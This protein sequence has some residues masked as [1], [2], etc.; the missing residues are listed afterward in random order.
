MFAVST[1]CR[2]PRRTP[3]AGRRPRRRRCPGP[4]SWCPARSATRPGRCDPPGATP[5]GQPSQRPR[6][7]CGP[8][9]CVRRDARHGLGGRGYRG[10]PVAGAH[11]AP[12]GTG[13]R[14]G[15]GSS[16]RSHAHRAEP[17]LRDDRAGVR[18]QPRAGRRP[19]RTS[20]TTRVWAAEAYGSDAVTVL[21]A[22]AARTERIDIG[23]AVLQIP[24]R[25]PAITAMTAATL[26]C[27]S[28][29]RFRLGLGVSG[30]Q[31]SEGWHGVRFTDPLGRTREYV[32]IVRQALQRRRVTAGGE[33]YTL[34]LPDGPGKSLVLSL[35]PVRAQ[36]PV[37]L[38][39]LGPK[40]LDLTGADRRRLAGHLLRPGHRPPVASTG[41]G[42]PP[43]A[44]GRDPA[45][46]DL[47]ASVPV[48]VAD[49][50]RAA[51]DAGP[52]ARR[53]VPRRDGVAE[54]ELLPPH[55]QRDGLRAGGGRG[56]GPVPG[57][58]L[59]GRRRRGAVRVPGP[60]R[61]ARRRGPDRGRDRPA[62]RRRGHQPSPCPAS[63]GPPEGRRR[64][65][66]H[67]DAG[68]RTAGVRG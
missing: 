56:A 31:V 21:A 1:G 66:A 54:D 37:Y 38:A 29:G 12:Q 24:G 19:R 43:A 6:R 18:R 15:T 25:T 33:H 17:R 61:P 26:D 20:D 39:A 65:A 30:P 16:G 68:G 63:T 10:R 5:S 32:Q 9:R 46:I 28:Q 34:P 40:N 11:R 47:C 42:T 57:P 52:R 41:S 67:R 55:R 7:G 23:S 62:G 36:I 14:R 53:A 13:R 8:S 50:P 35:Q 2:R 48:S 3:P 4:R 45:G 27:L 49:D 58:R 59:P 64:D 60:H 44:A 51:A 22:V